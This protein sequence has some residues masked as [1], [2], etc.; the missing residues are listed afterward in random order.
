LRTSLLIVY[1][2]LILVAVAPVAIVVGDSF[3]SSDGGL[4]LDHYFRAFGPLY[5]LKL[6]LN[7]FLIATL[8]TVIALAIGV[9]YAFF[10]TRVRTPL[11]GLFS[12]LYILPLV[13]P[14]LLMI[15]SWSAFLLSLREEKTGTGAASLLGGITGISFILGISYFPF[16][17]LFARKAFREIGAGLEEAAR[18]S[19]GPLTAFTKVTLRLSAPAICAGALFVFL[20]SIADFSVTDY[21]SIIAD[22]KGTVRA[23][24][25]EAFQIYGTNFTDAKLGR[26]EG[27]ALGLPLAVM[28]IGLLFV[29]MWLIRKDRHV[30][31]TSGHVS[32]TD[33]EAR[34]PRRTQI[35]FRSV[36]F[37]F[38]SAT[39]LVSVIV[40][41]GWI[42]RN[43]TVAG[44][45]RDGGTA[46]GAGLISNLRQT[47][48]D[49]GN[50]L[51]DV[52]S[53]L[54]FSAIAALVMVLIAAV[55]AHHMV[56]AGARRETLV[57]TLAFLPLAFGPIMFG[58]G[59]IR[60]WNHSYLEINGVNPIY[61]GV[62]IVIL[63]LVGK[64]LPFALAAVGSSVRRVDRRYED[65][66]AVAGVSWGRRMT[67]IVAPLTVPGLVGGFVL[68]FVFAMRELDTMA[69]LAGGNQAV[70][71]KIYRWVHFFRDEWV[72]SLCLV[73][74]VLIGLP[75]LL[76]VLLLSRRI[77]VL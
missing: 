54:T 12:A 35:L 27:A 55:L 21:V 61:D 60:M 8:S 67:G 32:P 58:A 18:M 29:I 49:P 17:V 19:A 22:T 77:R 36:G 47:L 44:P 31:V 7:S 45:G 74:I 70:I 4:T 28:C 52:G 25:F 37:L 14:P 62:I 53:S 64:Y 63:M 13:L 43:A 69:M 48:L 24:P 1:F 42:A 50:A 5:R 16:I 39:L 15:M 76:Y 41:V 38:L 65:V 59:L 34:S 72:W 9:P 56:R 68:A 73:L 10:C 33:I 6:L 11:R 40:P 51:P 2:L 75:F 66:A 3:V 57:M 71:L 20:F 23:Y 30:T 46:V 26:R